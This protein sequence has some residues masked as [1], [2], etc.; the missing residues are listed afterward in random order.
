MAVMK[1][2]R[3]VPGVCH[4]H[5]VYYYNDKFVLIEVYAYLQIYR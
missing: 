5:R 3:D 4:L 2:L 1:Q